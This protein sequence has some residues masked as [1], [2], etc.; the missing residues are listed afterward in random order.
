MRWR[1]LGAPG[2]DTEAR[3]RTGLEALA[4]RAVA[5]P[6]SLERILAGDSETAP[7]PASATGRARRRV[8]VGVGAGVAAVAVAAVVLSLALS[9]PAH[10]AQ[11]VSSAPPVRAL[12]PVAWVAGGNLHVAMP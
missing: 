8:P 4:G 9:P 7:V 10:R 12:T 5:S 11:V 6:D 1:R 3:L 2:P